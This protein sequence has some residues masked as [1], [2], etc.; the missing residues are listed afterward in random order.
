MD[1]Q[2][3]PQQY[4][5]AEID[6]KIR[7]M[8]EPEMLQILKSMEQSEYWI[9]IL[10]YNAVRLSMSQSALFAG[11]PVKDPTGMSRQQGIMLGLSDL[12]NGVIT[13]V[14]NAEQEAKEA[15]DQAEKDSEESEGT[16][17]E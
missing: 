13:M 3:M 9:A 7:T 2:K 5:T 14:Q 4:F 1:E 16:D 10:K 12:Q 8:T 6:E 17:V 15:H 11:D